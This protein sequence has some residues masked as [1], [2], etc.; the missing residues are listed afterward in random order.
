M[1]LQFDTVVKERQFYFEKLQSIELFLQNRGPTDHMIGPD[2]LKILYASEEEQV[3]V[4]ETGKLVIRSAQGEIAT[5]S[6]A[7]Q[8]PIEA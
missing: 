5:C 2:A 3:T 8:T 7:N 4:D 6:E 1:K